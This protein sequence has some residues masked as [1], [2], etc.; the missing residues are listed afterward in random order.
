MS[1]IKSSSALPQPLVNGRHVSA[2]AI[3]R[4]TARGQLAKCG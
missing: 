2:I 3:Q 4:R 1:C